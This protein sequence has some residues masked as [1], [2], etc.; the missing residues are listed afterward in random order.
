MDYR[1][2]NWKMAFAY[3]NSK[4]IRYY[5]HSRTSGR[6]GQGQ[7][8][9]FARDE[10]EGAVNELPDGYEVKEAGKSALPVIKK[11]TGK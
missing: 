11:K 7:I 2:I 1:K 3:T 6:G 5:L 8:F 10:R 9:F 4:G